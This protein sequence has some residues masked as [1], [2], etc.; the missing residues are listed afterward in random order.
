MR[1]RIT[2]TLPALK[3]WK[4]CIFEGRSWL[5][6]NLEFYRK[7]EDTQGRPLYKDISL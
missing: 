7:S 1:R 4:G 6:H 3:T 2:E 5:F